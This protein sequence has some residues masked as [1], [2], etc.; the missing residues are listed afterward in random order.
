M[1]DQLIG[2]PEPDFDR[3]P[4]ALMAH[5]VDTFGGPVKARAWLTTPNPVL[6][7]L[8]PL[9]IAATSEGVARVEE[10]LTRIDYG[11]FS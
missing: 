5:A 3:L 2:E 7:N 11:I 10:V 1:P 4:R 6:N 9:E 8:Q